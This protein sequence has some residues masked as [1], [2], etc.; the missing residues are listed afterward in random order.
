MRNLFLAGV[1]IASAAAVPLRAADAEPVL[2]VDLG[3]KPT[4]TATA[5]P[6]PTPVP[7]DTPVP[8]TPTALPTASS[9]PESPTAAAGDS[10]TASADASATAAGQDLSPAASAGPDLKQVTFDKGQQGE[11][12]LM[13][14]APGAAS[15]EDSLESFGI[16][17]PFNW[18]ARRGQTLQPGK[19]AAEANAEGQGDELQLSAP[20]SSSLEDR[21][22]VE[23]GEGE[24]LPSDLDYDKIERA[25]E[26]VN[27]T[28]YRVDGHVARTKDG[29]TFGKE[30]V[31][32]ALQMEPGRQV[33]PGSVYTLFRDAG[34]L[35]SS[36][37]DPH[38][39]GQ[40]IENVGVL[41]VT[42]IEGDE[43]L[44][45]IEKQYTTILSGDLIRLRD[46]DRLKFYATLREG[47]GTAPLDLKG[48]VIGLV[49]GGMMAH[50]GDPVYLNLGRAAGVVPGM[51]LLLWREAEQL[52]ADDER[53]LKATGRIGMV[54]VISVTHDACVARVVHCLG[55][56][57][58]GDKVRYR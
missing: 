36:G 7:T 1:L 43:V 10:A 33:Y 35:S 26:V 16:D 20:D 17:S 45:K 50:Q 14:I 40:L 42:R 18:R 2:E 21:V 5:T 9:G 15:P 39:V 38:E 24:T 51:R 29:Q 22:S 47:P 12:G 57:R 13:I 19:D 3:A 28:E 4:D 55:E 6:V 44:G 8:P 54:E 52:D 23:N 11:D 30:G 46:P 41:R 53:Q 25:G 31:Q 32:V 27:A 56:V 49:A 48:E 37:D 58:L 34:M